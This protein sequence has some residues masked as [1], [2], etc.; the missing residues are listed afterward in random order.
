M[1]QGPRVTS[2]D[3]HGKLVLMTLLDFLKQN[4]SYT[5]FRGSQ[6]LVIR[7]L[8][9]G[10]DVLALMPT[11]QGKSLC[12]QFLAKYMSPSPSSDSSQSLTPLTLVISPLIAL[13]QDQELQAKR[14]GLNAVFLSSI[15]SREGREQRQKAI[16]KGSAQIVFVTPERFRKPEFWAC[17]KSR[18][19][20]LMAV[21]EAHCISQWGHDFRPDYRRLGQIRE[22]LG[23]PPAQGLYFDVLIDFQDDQFSLF[24]KP[25][26]L[27]HQKRI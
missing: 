8:L 9:E 25:Q 7:S 23:Q 16:Q 26:S 5:A 22:E 20:G 12:F 4:F 21:D 11:G 15:L 24:Q 6:E 18:S 13:M 3:F 27:C 10:Q 14:L 2:P 1:G 19:I 17:L